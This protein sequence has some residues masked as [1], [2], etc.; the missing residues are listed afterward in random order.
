VAAWEGDDEAREALTGEGCDELK[1]GTLKVAGGKRRPNG[2]G[3][4]VRTEA[5]AREWVETMPMVTVETLAAGGGLSEPQPIPFAEIVTGWKMDRRRGKEQSYESCSVTVAT[6][7]REVR[8]FNPA[9]APQ[10]QPW[11][12]EDH[13]TIENR[14]PATGTEWQEVSPG[15]YVR[16]RG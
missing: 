7:C 8:R 13:A 14:R 12:A 3:K 2:H 4:M 16:L 9:P 11:A 15:H 1:T 10:P 5:V 6:D